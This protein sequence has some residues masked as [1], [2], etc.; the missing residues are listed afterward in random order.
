[1]AN[2]LIVSGAAAT[3]DLL[4]VCLVEDGHLVGACHDPAAAPRLFATLSFDVVCIDVHV[5][6]SGI[7]V[8]LRWLQA[9][10]ER[11]EIPVLFI[12][13]PR[14]RW[15][16]AAISPQMRPDLDDSVPLPLDADGLRKK[17]QRLLSR[18][19]SAAHPRTLRLPP[20]VLHRDTRELSA[21]GRTVHLTPTE[22]R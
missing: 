15:L 8:L 1:M 18:V 6:E 19:P 20:L 10:S 17:V 4:R 12:L 22:Y 2:V 16:P 14:R 11:S 3:S 13:P 9:G 7:D 5:G 21:G